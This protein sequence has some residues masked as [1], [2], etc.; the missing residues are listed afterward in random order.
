MVINLIISLY[1][2]NRPNPMLNLNPFPLFFT[3]THLR[4]SFPHSLVYSSFLRF[5]YREPSSNSR[6]FRQ[7]NKSFVFAFYN[8]SRYNICYFVTRVSLYKKNY[9]ILSLRKCWRY[10]GNGWNGGGPEIV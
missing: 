10:S 3:H 5:D 4:Y 7:I 1:P 2:S 6:F 9:I 8:C